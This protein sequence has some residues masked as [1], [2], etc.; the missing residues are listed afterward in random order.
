MCH[1]FLKAKFFT[2]AVKKF[3]GGGNNTMDHLPLSNI[4]GYIPSPPTPG[5]HAYETHE[6]G[7]RGDVPPS[8]AGRFCFFQNEFDELFIEMNIGINI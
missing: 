3:G 5:I 7:L 1:Q 6:G 4:V 8:E 2:I